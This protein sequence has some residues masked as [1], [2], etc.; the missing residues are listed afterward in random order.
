[1]TQ[2]YLLQKAIVFPKWENHFFYGKIEL[3]FKTH[4]FA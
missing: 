4:I 2:V 3:V 1:M